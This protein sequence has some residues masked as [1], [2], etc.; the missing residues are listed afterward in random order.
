[1]KIFPFS[2]DLMITLNIGWSTVHLLLSIVFLY[3]VFTDKISVN[4]NDILIDNLKLSSHAVI[5]AF[6]VISI[7][8]CLLILLYSID[9][10]KKE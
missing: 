5:V 8:A 6:L 4:K 2:N 7:I 3:L 10:S 1:M 9:L